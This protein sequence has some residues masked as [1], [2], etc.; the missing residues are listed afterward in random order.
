MGTMTAHRIPDAIALAARAHSGQVDKAGEPY[1]LHPIRV[2]MAGE[3]EAEK[4]VGFLHDVL[5][6]TDVTETR[7]RAFFG[8][9]IWRSLKSVTRE[10]G[11]PYEQ[12]ILRA[13]QDRVG[14]KVKINDLI[15]NLGRLDKLP[16]DIAK[17]LRKRYQ[18][19]LWVLIC[20]A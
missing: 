1:I 12:F 17:G 5:E 19:A 15:D 20:P 11:E 9:E 18:S 2:G 3:N 6:D 4:I 13:K 14:R 10:P 16:V 7:I 8:I